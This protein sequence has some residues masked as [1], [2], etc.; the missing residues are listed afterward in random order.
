M[1]FILEEE[2]SLFVGDCIL[3][4]GSA[5]FSDL[6]SYMKSLQSLRQCKCRRNHNSAL[7]VHLSLQR[8][9]VIDDFLCCSLC[10]DSE[11]KAALLRTRSVH[12]QRR[13]RADHS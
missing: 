10:N 9:G 4:T 5:V 6:S 13:S 12:R 8:L 1:T 11:T 7:F 3:G 2:N